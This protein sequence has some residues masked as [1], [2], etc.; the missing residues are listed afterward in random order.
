MI[1]KI[2][3]LIMSNINIVK[4]S[5]NFEFDKM[6][7]GAPTS[8][9]SQ[10]F[11]SKLTNDSQEFF[12]LTPPCK[13]K[14]GFISSSKTT[15]CDLMFKNSDDIVSFME[16]FENVIQKMIYARREKWFHDSIELDDIC[17][18]YTSDA[19]DE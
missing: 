2:Y 12:I 18:L 14:N 11:F 10:T 6:V 16:E 17:L 4:P 5:D 8:L 3:E 1:V 13:M 7:L 9:T 15:Y 19:A